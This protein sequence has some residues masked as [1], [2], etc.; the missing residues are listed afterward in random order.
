MPRASLQKYVKDYPA[1]EVEESDK[2]NDP[3]LSESDDD[4]ENSSPGTN[5]RRRGRPLALIEPETNA[6]R[7][8]LAALTIQ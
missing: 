1:P 8:R 5:F 7:A 2:E 6:L 3:E 4:K